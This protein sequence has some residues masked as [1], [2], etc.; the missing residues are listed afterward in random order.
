[1]VAPGAIRSDP[2]AAATYTAK[3]DEEVTGRIAVRRLGTPAEVAAT[4]AF[5][6]GADSSYLTGQTLLI[7]GGARW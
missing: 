1:M 5:L 7:D 2:L 4:V 3:E 6:A